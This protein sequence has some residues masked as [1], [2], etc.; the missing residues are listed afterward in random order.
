MRHFAQIGH[1]RLAG[2]VFT[3]Y[4]GQRRRVVAEGRAIQHLAQVYRLPL[5]VRQLQTDIR[6]TGD[7]FHHAHCRSRQRARQIARQVG[8]ARRFNARRQIQLEAGDDR[9]RQDVHH[10]GF[11]AI[12]G[13]AGLHQARLLF[14]REGIDRL[15]FFR[16]FGQQIQRRQRRGRFLQRLIVAHQERVNQAVHRRMLLG[17]RLLRLLHLH[18]RL[19]LRLLIRLLL[20]LLVL[21]RL[22]VRLLRLSSRR[23]RLKLTERHVVLLLAFQFNALFKLRRQ[24]EHRL[25]R[26]IVHQIRHRREAESI[27]GIDRA[28]GRRLRSRL[29]LAITRL[30]LL[31]E[32][33]TQRSLLPRRFVVLLV[34]AV[35]LALLLGERFAQ[36]GLLLSLF[37]ILLRRVAF[38]IALALLLGE[39]LAQ[40]GFL[41]RLFFL[42]VRRR[43]LLRL[44]LCLALFLFGRTLR[45]QLDAVGSQLATGRDAHRVR[46]RQLR[47][48][49][50]LNL[51][52]AV[53]G[54]REGRHKGRR[55]NAR[56]SGCRRIRLRFG[57]GGAETA[58]TADVNAVTLCGGKIK[59]RTRRRLRRGRLLPVAEARLIVILIRID[60][61][62]RLRRRRFFRDLEGIQRRRSV[63]HRRT[64]RVLIDRGRRGRRHRYRRRLSGDRRSNGLVDLCLH[65][66]CR[67]SHR[68]AGCSFCFK[69]VIVGAQAAEQR[70]G[71]VFRRRFGAFGDRRRGEQHVVI[72]GRGS[73]GGRGNRCGGALPCLLRLVVNV[74]L[75]I[76][77][78]ALFAA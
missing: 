21:L 50:L 15:H 51:R 49:A 3:Q 20:R 63:L 42:R 52:I 5:G 10:V 68:R 46:P 61:T 33:L 13:Q 2:D 41:Q 6:L 43:Q 75:V 73:G 72:G 39:R 53:A 35:T 18:L 27:A 69:L 70:I 38:A 62:R 30:L 56:S 77:E 14:Q 66:R 64:Y 17:L 55:R 60:R 25:A 22:R 16:R 23:R 44:R 74:T 32:C 26:A 36:L 29:L 78:I 57:A 11:H 12:I 48:D 28:G 31:G 40:R 1:H 45:R 34:F 71:G 8:N 9:P 19:L 4:D 67:R 37:I 58:R 7:H 24:R 59:G 65:R 76:F 54:R 47:A